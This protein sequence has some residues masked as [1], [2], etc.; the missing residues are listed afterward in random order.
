[1]STHSIELIQFAEKISEE[2]DLDSTVQFIEREKG[3][4]RARRFTL[5]D[6]ELLRKLGI[7]I[8]LLYKF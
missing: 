7:D 3:V 6:T 4:V 1:M 8:R 5:K 2:L